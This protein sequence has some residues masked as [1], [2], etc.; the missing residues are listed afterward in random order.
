MDDE[1]DTAAAVKITV[2]A[3][4]G[5]QDVETVFLTKGDA[6]ETPSEI[7]SFATAFVQD[8]GRQDPQMPKQSRLPMTTAPPRTWPVDWDDITADM[9]ANPGIFK[10]EGTVAG[11]AIKAEAFVQ[12]VKAEDVADIRDLL[13]ETYNFALNLSTDGVTDSAKAFFEK[14]MTQ[15]KAALDNPD[16]TQEELTTAWVPAGRHL[17][18]GL[19]Q[20]DK[21]ISAC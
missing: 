4:D 12:V 6:E 17:G 15:A 7:V 21:R 5:T 2:T 10:V 18:P 8:R 11:T 14:A 16:A 3:E 9:V 19:V 20:A 1:L 13:Q